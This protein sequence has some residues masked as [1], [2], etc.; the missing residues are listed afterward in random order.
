MPDTGDLASNQ[1]WFGYMWSA[2]QPDV[3]RAGHVSY[4]P[5]DGLPSIRGLT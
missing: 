1:E 5:D 4:R 2:D 3:F